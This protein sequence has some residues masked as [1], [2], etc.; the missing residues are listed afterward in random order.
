L[1]EEF[2]KTQ[3]SAE[4]ALDALVEHATAIRHPSFKSLVSAAG[5][6]PKYDLRGI[7]FRELDFRNEDL[8]GFDFSECDLTNS[9]FRGAKVD[10][11]SFK[12]ARLTGTVGLHEAI[13]GRTLSRIKPE[14]YATEAQQMI[15]AGISPPASWYDL[16]EELDFRGTTIGSLEPISGLVKLKRLGLAQTLVKDLVPLATL[17]NL[18][19]LDISYTGVTDLGVLGELPNLRALN[20][21]CTRVADLSPLGGL[22]HLER[23]QL[24]WTPVQDLGPIAKRARLR[25]L[26][27]KGTRIPPSVSVSHLEMVLANCQASMGAR[28][29]DTAV[30]R[31]HLGYLL[32]ELGESKRAAVHLL[33]ALPTLARIFGTDPFDMAQASPSES[34][35]GFRR[36]L[37]PRRRRAG[38]RRLE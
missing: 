20:I 9:D 33:A 19:V 26:D 25:R 14:A 7:S 21:T 22:M 35:I 24:A 13:F 5:L 4:H 31:A 36:E 6:D 17:S 16:I 27:V 38:Q 34:P 18:E 15:L 3:L 1:T 8:R 11:A 10:G 30:A 29:F 12:N 2:K 37:R 23:L 28:S 32:F